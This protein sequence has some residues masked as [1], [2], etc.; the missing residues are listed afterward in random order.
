MVITQASSKAAQQTAR[1]RALDDGVRIAHETERDDWH[2][3]QFHPGDL[4]AA[5]LEI[6]TDAQNDFSGHWMPVGGMGWEAKVDQHRTVDFTGIE[7]QCADPEALAEK[8]AGI[9][10]VPAAYANDAWQVALN[11]AQLSFIE[12]NDDRGPGLSGIHLRVADKAGI[13]RDAASRGCLVTDSSVTVGGV[14]WHLHV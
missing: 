7:L 1:Q 14:R 11:N 5:F 12:L 8:W 13:Q 10:G 4:Q 2:L 9:I 3:I 6:E